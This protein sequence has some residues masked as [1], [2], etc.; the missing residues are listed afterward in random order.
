MVLLSGI[1]ALAIVSGVAARPTAPA[2]SSSSSP[3]PAV[4][5][6]VAGRAVYLAHCESCH[7]SDGQGTNAGPSLIGVGAA[8]ADFALRTGRMP[9]SGT[10]GAQPKQKPPA[11]DDQTIRELVA[12]IASLGPGPAIPS[13]IVNNAF[14][15][16]GQRLFVQNCAPCHGVAATGGAVGQGW[17]APSLDKSSPVQVVEAMLIGPGQMPVFSGLSDADR[18]AIASYV[19]YLQTAPT[20]GGFSIGGIGPVP[21]GYVAWIVGL[22]LMVLIIVLVAHDWRRESP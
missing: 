15:S 18:N 8:S 13:P 7:G 21:E 3:A 14:V 10:T 20:P 9:Y 11:F 22:G 6:I 2:G 4:S 12:Y 1:A 5:D 16:D 17:L 19:H